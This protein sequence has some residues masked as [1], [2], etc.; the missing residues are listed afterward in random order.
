VATT[1]APSLAANPGWAALARAARRVGTRAASIAREGAA[2][3]LGAAGLAAIAVGAGAQWGWPV[4]L[5][6]GGPLAVWLASLLPA[7]ERK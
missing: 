5:M 1:P 3:T 2:S 4:G 6:V 7:G